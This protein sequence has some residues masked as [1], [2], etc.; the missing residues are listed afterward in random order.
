MSQVTNTYETYD[1]VG[2][3]EELA[4]KIGLAEVLKGDRLDG[5][6]VDFSHGDVDA[7]P[8]SPG[9]FDLFSAGVALGGAQAYTEY[10]GDMGIRELLAPRLAGFTGPPVDARDGLIITPG[11]QGALFLAVASTVARGD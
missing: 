2:N 11:T 10:R 6:P 5:R 7:H 4:D 1:A 3:R 9:S 8:P